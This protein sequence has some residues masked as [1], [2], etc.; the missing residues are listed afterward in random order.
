[1]SEVRSAATVLCLCLEVPHEV[2][3]E[4]QTACSA[5]GV[6]T[7][8]QV[9]ASLGAAQAVASEGGYSLVYLRDYKS[10][11]FTSAIPVG[12]VLYPPLVALMDAE[13]NEAVREVLRLNGVVAIPHRPVEA[14]GLADTVPLMK[15]ARSASWPSGA[16]KG[17]ASIEAAFRASNARELMISVACTHRRALSPVPWSPRLAKCKGAASTSC[18][19]WLGRIYLEDGD[20][21]T[22]AEIPGAVGRAALQTI[23]ELEGGIV[24]V[25]EVF[26]PPAHPAACGRWSEV[27]AELDDAKPHGRVTARAPA[28]AEGQSEATSTFDYATSATMTS[29]ALAPRIMGAGTT[30]AASADAGREKSPAKESKPMNEVDKVLASAPGLKSGARANEQGVVLEMVGE[31]DAEQLCAV[32]AMSNATLGNAGN[33]L[34]LGSLV[35]WAVVTPTTTVYV[36]DKGEGG[37]IAVIGGANKN[38]D[39]TL[40]KIHAALT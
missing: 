8:L 17:P 6:E 21:I 34:G 13:P 14:R 30:T 4:W 7:D 3:K 29:A 18:S 22:H 11:G 25:H 37:F 38:P 23:L 24:R 5:L 19:G 33:V 28:L 27:L 15:L 1:M 32:V 26:L 9:P 16:M 39:A 31:V 20:Q 36:H 35:R 12:S 2:V 40:T 10:G